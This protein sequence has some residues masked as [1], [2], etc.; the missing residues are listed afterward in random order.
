MVLFTFESDYSAKE[1]GAA[2]D[3]VYRGGV[4]VSG[5]TS[6]TYKEML[7]QSKITAYIL[8][9]S[10]GMAA[11]AIDSYDKLM[12]FIKGGGDY[13]KDSP[14]AP[15]AYKLS[16]LADN[17]PARLS[18]T[19]AYDVTQ[20]ERVNQKVLVRLKNITV[21]DDGGD[22]GGNLEVYGTITAGATNQVSLFDKNGD[23]HLSIAN[24]TTYPASA[25]TFLSEAIIDVNPSAGN[26]IT[27]GAH[28]LDDDGV[29]DDDLGTENIPAP[30]ETGWRREVKVRLTGAGASVIA[31]IELQP[32]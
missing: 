13:S 15:I 6:V 5:N 27:L 19:Q 11:Q 28:L 3:F 17:A 31:T 21:E 4:E 12:E 20:C 8:G 10:G 24:G 32:I 30:Y 29:G 26:A 25:D 14:G 16:Y 2:L 9:G 18:L 23:N 7:S 1:I 22:A